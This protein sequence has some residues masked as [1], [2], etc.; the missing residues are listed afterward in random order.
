[1]SCRLAALAALAVLAAAAAPAVH[2]QVL[3]TSIT[4]SFPDPN[5][6][7]PGFNLV[8]GA[9][10][11]NWSNSLAQAVLTHGS[12]YNYCVS[13]GSGNVTGKA[14]V[15]FKLARG[16]TVIQ[17]KVIIPASKFSVGANGVWYYCSGYLQLPSSPGIATLSGIV[18]FKATGSTK[19]VT[20]KVAYPVLLQ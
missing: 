20:S 19:P 16:A 3:A 10:I 11:A 2:G 14:T 18:A 9:G 15:S 8:P 1:M 5:G 6:K 13:L 12:Y 7:V 4:A 17:S